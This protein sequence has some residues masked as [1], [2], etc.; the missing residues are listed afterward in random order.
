MNNMITEYFID[1]EI[2]K[3]YNGYF[4]SAAEAITI[5]ILESLISLKHVSQIHQR[6]ADER[7]GGFL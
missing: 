4:C 3:K 7:V 6:T 5:V 2:T 1:V